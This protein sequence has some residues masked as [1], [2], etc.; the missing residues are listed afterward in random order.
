MNIENH[1]D[2]KQFARMV[3]FLLIKI[4][5]DDSVLN[6]VFIKR[7]LVTNLYLPVYLFIYTW[8]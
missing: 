6:E 2:F 8:C 4:I 5:I 3:T 1:N 7:I